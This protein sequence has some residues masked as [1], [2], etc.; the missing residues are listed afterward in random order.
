MNISMCMSRQKGQLI[1]S[2]STYVVYLNRGVECRF[3]AV[4]DYR[5]QFVGARGPSCEQLQCR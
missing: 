4:R 1:Y 2:V 5:E 3:A